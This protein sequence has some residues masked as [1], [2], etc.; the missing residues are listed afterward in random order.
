MTAALNPDTWAYT[1]LVA[2]MVAALRRVAGSRVGLPQVYPAWMLIG[3]ALSFVIL[4]LL[5]R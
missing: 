5:W 1:P 2:W 3:L 4:W